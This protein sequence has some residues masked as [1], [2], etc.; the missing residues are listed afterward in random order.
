MFLLHVLDK[1]FSPFYVQNQVRL[2]L[3]FVAL[4]RRVV[5]PSEEG[6]RAEAASLPAH[7]PGDSRRWNSDW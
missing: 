4:Q 5:S 2:T 7:R 6:K 1:S 3:N